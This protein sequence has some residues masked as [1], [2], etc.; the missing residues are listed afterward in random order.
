MMS[1][2]EI[3][4]ADLL[5]FM[6]AVY[7]TGTGQAHWPVGTGRLDNGKHVV[8]DE[9]HRFTYPDDAEAACDEMLAAA[10]A[11]GAEVYVCPYLMWAD[12]RTPGGT[13]ERKLLHRDWDGEAANLD[14]C[15][16]KVKAIGGF[17][18]ASG[19]P[20]HL[21]VFVPLA[22]NV[23]SDQRRDLC[24]ALSD[25]L[26]PGSDKGKWQTNDLLR[27]PG[28]IHRKGQPTPVTWAIRPNGRI[29]LDTLRDILGIGPE[30]TIPTAQQAAGAT[31]GDEP[32]VPGPSTL[33]SACDGGAGP[34]DIQ[35]RRHR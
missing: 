24:K 4:R 26:P 8:W 13:V 7:G 1:D 34:V 14:E 25:Y 35:G 11:T 28:T 12:K 19:T 15:I 27:P 21:H 3:R 31:N 5:A 22:E 2:I 10:D 9:T 32:V 33:L 6:Q 29:D 18:V 17:A 20:G 16:E 30:A 23:T